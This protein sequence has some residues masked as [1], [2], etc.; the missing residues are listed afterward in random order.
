M[1]YMVAALYC[2]VYCTNN[3]NNKFEKQRSELEVI[4]SV[5]IAA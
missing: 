2:T 3:N 5:V 4:H 1:L